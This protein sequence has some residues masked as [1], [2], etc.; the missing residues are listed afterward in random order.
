MVVVPTRELVQQ[1]KQVFDMCVR[2]MKLNVMHL[3]FQS[4]SQVE[5]AHGQRTLVEEQAKLVGPG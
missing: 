2:K 3:P 5:V 4:N 1:A